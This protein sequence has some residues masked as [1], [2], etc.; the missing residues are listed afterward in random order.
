MDV[1]GGSVKSGIGNMG[2]IRSSFDSKQLSQSVGFVAV[3]IFYVWC[4]N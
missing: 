2:Y 1:A 4:M 3:D